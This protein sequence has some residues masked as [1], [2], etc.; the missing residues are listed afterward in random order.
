[1]RINYI[2]TLY[3]KKDTFDNVSSIKIGFDINGEAGIEFAHGG[4]EYFIKHDRIISIVD[5]AEPKPEFAAEPEPTAEADDSKDYILKLV[6][7]YGISEINS[8]YREDC[9]CFNFAPDRRYASVLTKK[10][11]ETILAHKEF[12]CK[13]FMASDFIMEEA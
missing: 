10:E 5:D 13:Q 2:N 1:M 7:L 9:D 11:C 8:Y 12:Y 4:H 3:N 6:G